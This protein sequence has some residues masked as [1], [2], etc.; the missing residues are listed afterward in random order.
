VDRIEAESILRDALRVSADFEWSAAV[1]RSVAGEEAWPQYRRAV[2][3]VMG[4]LYVEIMR[5]IERAYPGLAPLIYEGS[6]FDESQFP[7]PPLTQSELAAHVLQFTTAA[8]ECAKKSSLSLG[9]SA[10]ATVAAAR[11]ASDILRPV[12]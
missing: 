5:P 7:P 1:F 8:A 4:A 9:V 12:G 10:P 11:Q 2:G 3:Q 6:L